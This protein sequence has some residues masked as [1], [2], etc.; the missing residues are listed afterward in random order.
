[1]WEELLTK[2]KL[3]P[4]PTPT[5]APLREALRVPQVWEELRALPQ[6]HPPWE[7]R[8]WMIPSDPQWAERALVIHVL[9][10]PR[11]VGG[12]CWRV[13]LPSPCVAVIWLVINS[14]A[15]PRLGLLWPCRS[16]LRDLSR[17]LSPAGTLGSIFCALCSCWGRV[18]VALVGA[19]H[20]ASPGA[21]LRSFTHLG[22][23]F[24]A[25]QSLPPVNGT[26]SNWV[27]LLGT[28]GTVGLEGDTRPFQNQRRDGAGTPGRA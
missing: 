7:D 6:F 14:L 27:A 13:S 23:H 25:H 12:S 18:R 19:W 2:G 4:T 11:L 1:M 16:L 20:R 15:V 22:T 24:W 21:P 8:C 28:L 10:Y 5:E 9:G 26:G 17:S 3:D